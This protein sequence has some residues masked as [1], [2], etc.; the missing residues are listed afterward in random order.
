MSTDIPSLQKSKSDNKTCSIC[1][2]PYTGYRNNARPRINEHP[3]DAAALGEKI[4]GKSDTTS[5]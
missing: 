2:Q 1:Y 4:H 5:H 3:A